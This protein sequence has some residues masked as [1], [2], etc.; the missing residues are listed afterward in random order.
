MVYKWVNMAIVHG[1]CTRYINGFNIQFLDDGIWTTQQAN[2]VGS[3]KILQYS[4]LLQGKQLVE[5]KSPELS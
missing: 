3:W 5:S 4:T 1:S 2:Q